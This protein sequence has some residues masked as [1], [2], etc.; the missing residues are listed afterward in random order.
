VTTGLYRI[1]YVFLNKQNRSTCL[2]FKRLFIPDR[3]PR[4]TGENICVVPD[5]GWLGWGGGG[6]GGG[7]LGRRIFGGCPVGTSF[8]VLNLFRAARQISITFVLSNGYFVVISI[9]NDC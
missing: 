3:G 6:G 5:V 4:G 9:S 8:R 2:A 7:G 1:L